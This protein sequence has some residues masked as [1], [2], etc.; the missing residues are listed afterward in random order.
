[1]I[2]FLAILGLAVTLTGVALLSVPWALIVGGLLLTVAAS[3][4]QGEQ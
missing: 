3:T 1:M 2:V 4:Y